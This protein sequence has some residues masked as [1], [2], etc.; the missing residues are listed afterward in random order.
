MAILTIGH[1]RISLHKVFRGSI[2]ITNFIYIVTDMNRLNR[3]EIGGIFAALTLVMLAAVFAFSQAA[4][5]Q[6][7]VDPCDL[8]GMVMFGCDDENGNA[9]V[10][11]DPCDITP[12]GDDD[13]GSMAEQINCEIYRQLMAAGD[14]I[15][16]G[17]DASGCDDDNGGGGGDTP[18]CADDEDNDGDGLTD[19]EDPGCED[20]NDDDEANGGGG[21]GTPAC[22]DN[23]DNDS[24]GKTDMEDPGCTDA[25]DTD[26]TDPITGGGGG[27]SGGGSSGGSGGGSGGGGGTVLGTTSGGGGSCHYLTKFIKPGADNDFEQVVRLQAFLKVFEGANVDVNGTYDAAS[28]AAVHA[29][30]SKY[31]ADIL[32]PWE[33]NHSTGYVYLTTRKKINEIYCDRGQTFP[34]TTEEIQIVEMTKMQAAAVVSEPRTQEPA[35]EEAQTIE[36]EETT[37]EEEPVVD[38]PGNAFTNF[39]RRLFDRLR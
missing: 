35:Q 8:P 32:A 24:D 16:Q 23:T 13:G 10:P 34:L 21:N 31:V 38:A 15:P 7:H 33:I 18:A 2:H 36:E 20:S 1:V 30:Q 25:N 39:F 3:L 22:S 4:Y 19:N 27:S 26:E 12:C 37:R 6:Q 14:P 11:V 9:N 29:F 17:F 28:I 5:A